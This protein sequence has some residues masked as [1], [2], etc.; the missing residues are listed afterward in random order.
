MLKSSMMTESQ[1]QKNSSC[2]Q[3]EKASH[4]Q[5]GNKAGV[6]LLYSSNRDPNTIK[7]SPQMCYSKWHK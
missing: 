1:G 4:L 6:K 5:G 2:I 3:A 7:Q